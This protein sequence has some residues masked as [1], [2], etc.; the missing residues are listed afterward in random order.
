AAAVAT[1]RAAL[2][3]W[4]GPALVD[5]AGARFAREPVARLDELR[6]AA[7][8]DRIEA[9]LRLGAGGSLVAELEALVVAEPLR[10]PLGGQLMRALHAA[11]RPNDALVAYEELRARLADQLGTDPSAELVALHTALLRSE[12]AP[13]Q[14]KQTNLRA[15]LTS[16]VGRDHELSEVGRLL[17]RSRLT[18]LTGPGGAG[19]TRL[20][21][22][23]ARAALTTMPDGVW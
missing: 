9:E 19:K 12:P 23:A 16:F 15:E 1:L 18:T 3:L 7:V 8:Q 10:E 22:E 13:A 11:G 2:D 4:R 6:L 20:A 14:E 21:V 5:V 17:D